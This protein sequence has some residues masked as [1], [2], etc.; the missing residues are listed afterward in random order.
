[1]ADWIGEVMSRQ[2]AELLLRGGTGE[3]VSVALKW[4][5]YPNA[6]SPDDREWIEAVARIEASGVDLRYAL[7]LR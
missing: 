4:R 1:M 6:T 5:E 7:N 3:T 2:A